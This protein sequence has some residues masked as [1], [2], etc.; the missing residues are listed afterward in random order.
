VPPDVVRA[1][2]DALP[3]ASWA[4]VARGCGV[5]RQRVGQA[6]RDGLGADVLDVWTLRAR[7]ADR[8]PPPEV[9]IEP[10]P[11]T[12]PSFL[13]TP[14]LTP[15]KTEAWLRSIRKAQGF[16]TWAQLAAYLGVHVS[17]VSGWR[18]HGARVGVLERARDRVLQRDA[19]TIV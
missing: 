13:R 3:G 4:D 7:A 16:A 2:L 8:V 1:R 6:I 15:A 10:V 19:S 11:R 14:I 17:T 9:L 5:S 18:A 12:G